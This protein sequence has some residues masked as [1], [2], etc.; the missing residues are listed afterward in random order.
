MHRS[1]E[2]IAAKRW[3]YPDTRF[4]RPYRRIRSTWLDAGKAL[5]A[6]CVAHP[7]RVVNSIFIAGVV[8]GVA[9]RWT[10]PRSHAAAHAASPMHDRAQAQ[11]EPP[12]RVAILVPLSGANR[13]LGLSHLR[14]VVAGLERVRRCAFDSIPL[15]ECFEIEVTDTA[16]FRDSRALAREFRRIQSRAQVVFGPATSEDASAL[17]VEGDAK[18]RIPTILTLAATPDVERHSQF[19]SELLQLSV[20]AGGYARQLLR[21]LDACSKDPCHSLVCVYQDD[22]FGRSCRDSLSHVCE[23]EGIPFSRVAIPAAP[24]I[25]SCSE[26]DPTI[27]DTLASADLASHDVCVLAAFGATLD[28]ALAQMS[29]LPRPRTIATTGRVPLESVRKDEYEGLLLMYSY[30]PEGGF[31][32]RHFTFESIARSVT[33]D[34]DDALA[35]AGFASV[36][37]WAV[38]NTVGAEAHDA[39]LLWFDLHYGA[40]LDP[41]VRAGLV[42]QLATDVKV[43]REC[44]DSCEANELPRVRGSLLVY[45][46][47]RRRLVLA[48]R[49]S[50]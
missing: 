23:S 30:P 1:A 13:D 19:G 12:V 41:D 22:V 38:P 39:A 50:P 9:G 36:V 31:Y 14:G 4:L 32:D 6:A 18:L 33:D 34:V 20:N 21:Y 44:R 40:A 27:G 48:E 37:S 28:L 24:G 42:D 25:E 15:E 10:A 46:V 45:Q 43:E 49:R 35:D 26:R 16:A 47:T 8:A 11:P 3:R 5:K 29:E 2:P 17:L 7:L